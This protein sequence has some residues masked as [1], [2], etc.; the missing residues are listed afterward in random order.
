MATFL[1]GGFITQISGS[2]GGTTFR[3]VGSVNVVSNK[4]GGTSKNKLRSNPTLP[5]LSFLLRQWQFLNTDTKN[6]W[7]SK[8]LLYFFPNKYG[9]MTNLTGRQFFIKLNS[10]GYQNGLFPVDISTINNEFNEFTMKKFQVN[11]SLKTAMVDLSDVTGQ[12]Y[13]NIRAQ[14][15]N[16]YGFLPNF[17]RS[18]II[19]SVGFSVD[20][21]LD[22]YARLEERFGTFTPEDRI[23][24][25]VE[26]VNRYGFTSAVRTI[27][28]TVI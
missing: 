28:A 9:V 24:L 5:F 27:D 15:V 8:A 7:N 22:I 6:A 20:T 18:K 10:Q 2:V 25:Y 1:L 4:S 26:P 13:I 3:K 23:R 19:A 21:D 17:T 16:S 11:F 12:C 14:K